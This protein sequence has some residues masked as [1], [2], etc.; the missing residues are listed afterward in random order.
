MLTE[1]GHVRQRHASAG[2]RLAVSLAPAAPIEI[3]KVVS[4]KKSCCSHHASE[5]SIRVT[6]A[7]GLQTSPSSN[8]ASAC[9]SMQAPCFVAYSHGSTDFLT[10]ISEIGFAYFTG[11]NAVSSRSFNVRRFRRR[12]GILLIAT[13]RR[14]KSR[15]RD[16]FENQQ[17]EL[18]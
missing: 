3:A 18:I 6:V 7:Q 2:A 13:V 17:G 5:S 1:Q 14:A 12:A 11:D 16:S 10:G 9:C 4:P 15:G 8:S